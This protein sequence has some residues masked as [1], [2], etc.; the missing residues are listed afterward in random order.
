M[1]DKIYGGAL[2]GIRVIDWTQ[3]AAGPAATSLLGSL[4]AEVIHVEALGRGDGARGTAKL[5]GV[6]CKLKANKTVTFEN[7]NRN[8][9]SIAIDLKKQN[10]RKII[11]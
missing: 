1:A 4:G 3:F 10:G 5:Y 2:Q 11:R 6:N 7:W 9:K 8:K